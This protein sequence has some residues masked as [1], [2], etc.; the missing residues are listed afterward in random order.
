M[1]SSFSADTGEHPAVSIGRL[2]SPDAETA[3]PVA[4][5]RRMERATTQLAGWIA[6]WTVWTFGVLAFLATIGTHEL[7]TTRL[8][9]TLA[10][11]IGSAVLWM[12]VRESARARHDL[13]RALDERERRDRR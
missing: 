6:A 10:W 5:G 13:R 9:L 7:G 3:D 4:V 11:L 1:P 8:G 12:Q 2:V